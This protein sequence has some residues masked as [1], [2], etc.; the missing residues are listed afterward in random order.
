MPCPG[1]S[2]SCEPELWSRFMG[3]SLHL[4]QAPRSLHSSL[5]LYALDQPASLWAVFALSTSL[6]LTAAINRGNSGSSLAWQHCCLIL[7][8]FGGMR[9]TADAPPR[10][11]E[12]ELLCLLKR[13]IFLF[14][15][16]LLLFFNEKQTLDVHLVTVPSRHEPQ[17]PSSEYLY[18]GI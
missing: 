10:E 7:L 18:Y 14:F 9:L 5:L 12:G 13:K 15:L 11:R 3:V 17:T 4:R 1:V 2:G 16:S 8:L 6:N